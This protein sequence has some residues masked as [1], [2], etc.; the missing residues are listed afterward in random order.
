MES[1][2]HMINDQINT[3]QFYF[4]SGN[5]QKL[6]DECLKLLSSD[7]TNPYALDGLVTAYYYDLD[8][9]END[10]LETSEKCLIYISE[11][12]ARARIFHV[13]TSYYVIKD[14]LNQAKKHIDEA[15]SLCPNNALYI[16]KNARIMAS[17][18]NKTEFEVLINTAFSIEPNNYYVLY[19]KF[20]AYYCL[21]NDKDAE[22]ALLE[23]ML[24][25]SPDS[26]TMNM[27][28]A[29]HHYKFREF[30]EAYDFFVKAMLINPNSES[31]NSILQ[32]L[33]HRIEEEFLIKEFEKDLNQD[34]AIELTN[35]WR[36]ASET[37]TFH[38]LLHF[39]QKL[40]SLGISN[41]GFLYA[42]AKSAWACKQL[43]LCESI[44]KR[45][46]RHP[47]IRGHIQYIW[48]CCCYSMKNYEK[49]YPHL[50]NALDINPRQLSNFIYLIRSLAETGKLEE[51]LTCIE[52]GNFFH[53][54][55]LE[56]LHSLYIILY[57]FSEDFQMEIET[58]KKLENRM[59]TTNNES[60]CQIQLYNAMTYEKYEKFDLAH[61]FL[62]DLK[63]VESIKLK[64][65]IENRGKRLNGRTSIFSIF[66][67][68]ETS[69]QTYPL[70]SWEDL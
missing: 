47:S 6:K 63:C 46:A 20:E 66:K 27:T 69:R 65:R 43:H 40:D 67:R 8:N 37:Q 13:I 61:I 50:K 38:A 60:F 25:L 62:K 51:A 22:R 2:V 57:K 42:Y 32:D 34:N 59:T 1:V 21:Y 18:G 45:A 53:K 19:E 54:E 64:H 68:K 14:N 48:G 5:Y 30:K 52:Q 23:K 12:N 35:L 24:P 10:F 33:E 9:H 7:P 17:L 70:S 28:I 36:N 3:I 49:A 29:N 44:C 31:L 16:A 15:L 26:F 41:P 39:C 58:L 11:P 55:S 4:N 56:V